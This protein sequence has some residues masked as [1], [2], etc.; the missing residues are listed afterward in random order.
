MDFLSFKPSTFEN[1][2]GFGKS[3]FA[4][5]SNH[6]RK[7]KRKIKSSDFNFFYIVQVKLI[8]CVNDLSKKLINI[9]KC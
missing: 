1:E 3:Q 4:N 5:V 7:K 8:F 2:I 9:G 6:D